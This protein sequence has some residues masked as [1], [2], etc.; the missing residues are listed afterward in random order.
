MR[1]IA[2]LTAAAVA[3]TIFCGVHMPREPY[4][5]MPGNW[6]MLPDGTRVRILYITGTTITTDRPVVRY[7]ARLTFHSSN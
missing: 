6:A 4:E 2:I 7:V 5:I 1:L 3:F